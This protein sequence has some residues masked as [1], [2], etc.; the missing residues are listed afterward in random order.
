MNN[1]T[2][3][4]G[5]QFS[6][7]V[8]AGLI[9]LFNGVTVAVFIAFMIVATAFAACGAVIGQAA[10]TRTG[11]TFSI[12]G[13]LLAAAWAV[14]LGSYLATDTIDD[15]V[16]IVLLTCLVGF[17]T[18]LLIADLYGRMGVNA[19]QESS[20]DMVPVNRYPARSEVTG[21][22]LVIDHAPLAQPDLVLDPAPEV[23]D[24]APELALVSTTTDNDDEGTE[25]DAVY[26]L[27]DVTAELRLH[28]P[29]DASKILG[30][31][32]TRTVRG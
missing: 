29:A 31:P 22:E 19:N 17:T 6:D 13:F 1:Q 28:D 5:S 10:K 23:V 32:R 27:S 2:A 15:R 14:Q 26:Q 25:P 21:S 30:K 20:T 18:A 12:I 16:A 9:H 8:H 24:T 4:T 3:I 7:D 11:A